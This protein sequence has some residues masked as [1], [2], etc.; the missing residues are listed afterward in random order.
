MERESFPS[1]KASF[2]CYSFLW[3][4]AGAGTFV[5]I[6]RQMYLSFCYQEEPGSLRCAFGIL[7]AVQAVSSQSQL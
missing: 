6:R 3:S 2:R 4:Q 7:E 1:W 5:F